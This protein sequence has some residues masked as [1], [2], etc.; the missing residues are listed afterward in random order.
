MIS[1]E[2]LENIEGLDD[3]ICELHESWDNRLS[4]KNLA[5]AERY[6]HGGVNFGWD[7]IV[8]NNAGHRNSEKLRAVCY[9]AIGRQQELRADTDHLNAGLHGGDRYD[10][11]VFVESVK[12]IDYPKRFIPSF[13][14]L[15]SPD[16]FFSDRGDAL[17]FSQ[18]VGQKYL[19]RP[20]DRKAGPSSD[21]ATVVLNQGANQQV[22]G[23]SEIV[24]DVADKAR[25][26]WRDMLS[27]AGGIDVISRF[28]LDLS[29]DTY[30][31]RVDEL[32]NLSV[33]IVDVFYGPYNL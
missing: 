11:L 26:D 23:R 4:V 18:A 14:W 32:P 6:I 27:K 33:E 17:Y 8:W 2:A 7:F 12:L 20:S 28:R 10:R 24:S 31:L 16:D 30:R 9:A 15:E 13:V 21:L 19:F 22:K 25:P 3:A 29:D 1:S 5:L